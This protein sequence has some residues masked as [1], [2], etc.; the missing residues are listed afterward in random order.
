MTTSE[1]AVTRNLVLVCIEDHPKAI[2]MLRIARRRAQEI[3]GRWRAIYVETPAHYQKA[4]D[5]PHERVLR[6]LTLAEQMGGETVQVQANNVEKG[7]TQIF[8]KEAAQVALVIIGSVEGEGRLRHLRTYPW[9]RLVRLASMYTQVEVIPL[10]G[11]YYRSSLSEKLNLRAIR[12]KHMLYALGAIGVASLVTM[13]LEWVL[14]PALFRINNQNVALI[15]MI[16]CAFVAGRYGL[17]PGLVASVS[18][19]LTVNYYFTTPYNALKLASITDILNMVLFL[20]AAL[21][22][23]LFT[24][25]TRGFAQKAAKRE[26]STHALFTLYR[27]AAD[28][29]SRKQ[30][31]EQLQSKLETMLEM[32]VAF[33]FPEE[34]APA[35][36]NPLYPADLVLAEADRKALDVCWSEM[37]TTGL[38]SPFDPG[39]QWR[40][41]P[42]ISPNGEV[43]VVGIRPR[44][45]TRLDAWFGRLLS[46]IA[47]QTATVLEHIDLERSMEE[48]RIRE[49]R[50][51]LRSM[52]LSSVSHDLKTPL[53]G[54]I[55]ALSVHRSQGERLSPQKRDEL[56]EAAMGEAQR[57]D[58][59]I[60]NILDMTRLESGNIRFRQEWNDLR[61]LVRNVHKNTQMRVRGHEIII[62]PFPDDV[63]GYMDAMMTEQVVQNVVDNALKYTPPGTK[64]EINCHVDEEK[65]ILIEIRD[66]G[67]GIPAGKFESVFDKYARLHKTDSQVAGTGLGLAISKAV[68]KAQGG[69]IVASNHPE[70]GAIFTFCIPKWR[71]VE[72]GKMHGGL[73]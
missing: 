10:S 1:I 33:F 67:A 26:L 65:G 63:E 34:N 28:A 22:I 20:S 38:A 7:M 55:G 17:L 2:R 16:A 57:L 52:L 24:S 51:K 72:A 19:F 48:T 12:P 31:L 61:T 54:I 71:K 11:Q 44:G 62:H 14:P 56:I 59:F 5:S 30:A 23:S 40:F 6:L 21:F 53:A 64:V 66:H 8:D 47:D 43:G 37:K 69:W 50:E 9:M 58:S 25:Q 60:T 18:G 41:E 4:A 73:A 15:F 39:A 45:K 35:R 70:G 46:A 36:I 3:G 29:F 49:E 42:M 27:I 68:M 13:L 32:D